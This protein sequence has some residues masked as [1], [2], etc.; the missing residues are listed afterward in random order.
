MSRADL[1]QYVWQHLGVRK[2]AVGRVCVNR[3]TRRAI[4]RWSYAPDADAISAAV[5][6][7][8]QGRADGDRALVHPERSGF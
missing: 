5:D 2:L 7:D 8:E 3:L 4:R 1:E 6:A